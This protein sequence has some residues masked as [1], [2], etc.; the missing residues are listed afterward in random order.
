MKRGKSQ[1]KERVLSIVEH[2][3]GNCKLVDSHG[4]GCREKEGWVEPR[5][6]C[7]SYPKVLPFSPL[8]FDYW[9]LT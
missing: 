8:S 2:D 5:V 9:P 6:R 7:E 3:L 4:W 1:A